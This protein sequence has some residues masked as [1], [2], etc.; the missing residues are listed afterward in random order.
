MHVLV[1]HEL[2]SK[3]TK[4]KF[5][6]NNTH[7]LANIYDDNFEYIVFFFAGQNKN[8]I[9]HGTDNNE[10]DHSMAMCWRSQTLELLLPQ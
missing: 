5:H 6:S 4:K 10:D 3:R 7:S 8:N 2:N 1:L 9:S